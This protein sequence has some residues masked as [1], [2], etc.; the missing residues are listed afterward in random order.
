MD[1]IIILLFMLLL[2]ALKGFFSGSEIALVNSDKIKLRHKAAKGHSGA[3]LVLKIF[4]TPE[5][6]FGTTLVGTNLATVSLTTIGTLLMIRYFGERGDLYALLAISPLTMI[7]GEIVPKSVY[8]QK[9]NVLAPVVIYPIRAFS[10]VFYPIVFVFSRLAR[11]SARLV[12]TGKTKPN[13]FITREQMR[14]IVEMAQMGSSVGV[15]DRDRIKR[16][17][18]F[19]DTT[20]GEAMVPVAEMVA[21]AAEETTVEA[22]RLTRTLGYQDLPVYKGNI[23]NVVGTLSLS[24]WDLIDDT[25]EKEPLNELIRPVLYVFHHQPIDQVLTRLRQRGDNIAI[26]VDE[27]GS[28]IGMISMEDIF[29]E[30]VG[31]IAMGLEAPETNGRHRMIFKK[32][33]EDAY[34][35]DARLPITDANEILEINLPIKDFHTLGG[36]IME[37]LRHIPEKDEFIDE[38]GYR[39]SVEEPT[40]RGIRTLRVQRL[41]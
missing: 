24:T 10:L 30:V 26:V 35:M 22:M 31:E 8:Q 33:S 3:K 36:L 12:G 41:I 5:I 18:R 28:A 14:S 21:I 9:A 29:E 13:P 15:F 34:L 27:F 23:S 19:A 2:L 39:F 11:L 17:V 38:S 20:V 32:L 16:A 1:L 25:L 37:H 40:E 7:L 4:Q 6:L